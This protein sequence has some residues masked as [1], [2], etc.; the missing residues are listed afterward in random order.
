[1]EN[2]SFLSLL[3]LVLCFCVMGITFYRKEQMV[4]LDDMTSA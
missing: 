2:A 1:M 3:F 4:I